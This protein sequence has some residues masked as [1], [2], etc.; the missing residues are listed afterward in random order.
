MPKGDSAAGK[1][2]LVGACAMAVVLIFVARAKNHD[3]EPTPSVTVTV[4]PTSGGMQDT[5]GT[6]KPTKK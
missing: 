2:A 6:A 3:G 4:H 5:I 1:L